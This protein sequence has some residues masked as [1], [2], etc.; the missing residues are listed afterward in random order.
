LLAKCGARFGERHAPERLYVDAQRSHGPGHERAAVRR[1]ARQT[2]GGAVD[3]AQFVREAEGREARR[4]GAERV[5]L[6]D[7]RAGLD[8]FLVDLADQVR[9]MNTPRE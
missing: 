1:F 9:L 6:Q 2:H 5:R 4:G 8:V 7:L 3:V